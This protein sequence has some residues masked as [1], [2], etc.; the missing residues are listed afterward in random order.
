MVEDRFAG[1]WMKAVWEGAESSSSV[2][3][4]VSWVQAAE[5]VEDLGARAP[6]MPTRQQLQMEGHPDG[7]S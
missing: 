6:R 7:R 3:R 1:C 2:D 4:V 5:T